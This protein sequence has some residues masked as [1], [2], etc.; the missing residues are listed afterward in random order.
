MNRKTLLIIC[1]SHGTDWG[2]VGYANRLK[3]LLNDEWD[4]VTL[5]Y[6]GISLKKIYSSLCDN[7]LKQFDAILLGIG[8]P[9]VHPRMPRAVIGLLKRLGFSSARDSYF[10]VP[11]NINLSYLLRLP[12]F[13]VRILTVRLRIE[14]YTSAP[15]LEQLISKTIELLSTKTKQLH[16]LP[17]FKVSEHIYGKTHNLN[18]SNLNRYLYNSHHTN[19]IK[20]DAIS[21]KHYKNNRNF[22][23]FHFNN[24]FQEKLAKTIEKVINN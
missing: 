9:D 4:T 1:D 2:C 13:L 16:I 14:T 12:L 24:S 19:L 15:E 6:P 3:S 8:N 21:E 7:E 23:F 11:P 17:I 22:D 10:S 18:A 5:A 20:D